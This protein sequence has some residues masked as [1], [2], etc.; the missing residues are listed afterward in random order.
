MTEVSSWFIDQLNKRA[1]EPKRVFTM[2]GSDH[3]SRVFKWPSIARNIEEITPVN[4]NIDLSN[5]DG[6]Y[7]ALYEQSYTMIASCH[8][9]I[10]FTHPESGDEL[11]RVYTGTVNRITYSQNICRTHIRDKIYPLSK[12]KIG[13][14]DEQ[15]DF[16]S[17]IPSE[18]AWTLCTCYGLLS[19]VKSSS[20][21]DINYGLFSAWAATFSADAVV[22]TANFQ[23]EKINEGLKDLV[24]HTDSFHWVDGDGKLVFERFTEASSLDFLI[25]EGEY[26]KFKLLVDAEDLIN[27]QYVSYDYSVGSD[28]WQ[29][30]AFAISSVSVN[31]FKLHEHVMESDNIWYTDSNHAT[32][33][34]SRRITRLGTP[35]KVFEL[36]LP[37]TG[38]Q[39]EPGDTLRLVNSFYNVSSSSGWRISQHKFNMNDFSINVMTNEALIANAFFL[40][41]SLL[42]GDDLLL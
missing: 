8:L 29:N 24:D 31:S 41:T 10:G 7:N 28:Y 15:V 21:I 37:L 35:P 4:V 5:V 19:D 17:Q 42:D 14:T 26:K 33:L 12:I 38:I 2:A 34:G 27:K 22:T 6:I 1:T 13:S 39:R 3:S 30:Q 9:D 40:D 32:N 18:I 25:G 20:N 23:G 16:S 11:V 36:D